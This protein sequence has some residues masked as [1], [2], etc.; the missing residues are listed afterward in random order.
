VDV[1]CRAAVAML[2]S[3]QWQQQQQ[4]QQQQQS[5]QLWRIKQSIT[6]THRAVTERDACRMKK[7]EEKVVAL[8]QYT[9]MTL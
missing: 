5:E 2:T 6:R 3:C 1:P 7:E 4:Q 9:S 8:L